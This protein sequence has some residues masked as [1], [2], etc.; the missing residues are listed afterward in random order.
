MET[1]QRA[2][3]GRYPS[4]PQQVNDMMAHLDV[5]GLILDCCGSTRDAVCRLLT[6]RGFRVQTNDINSRLPADT[7]L[8]A[9]GAD[10]VQAYGQGD[11]RP[12]WVVTSPPYKNAFA[13]LKKALHVAQVGVVFKLRLSFL[14]PSKTLGQWLKDNPP[15]LTI[16]LPRAVYRGRKCNVP[17]AWFMWYTGEKAHCPIAQQVVFAV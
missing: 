7:H 10:F 13:I 11:N 14:E 17:E 6:E 3:L 15:S 16:V 5:G 8:D 1:G 12:D 9:S 2:L 4:L